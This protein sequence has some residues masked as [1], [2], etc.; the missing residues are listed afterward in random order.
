MPHQ[1]LA[2]AYREDS[3]SQEGDF[4]ERMLRLVE[5]ISENFRTQYP[6]LSNMRLTRQQ[7]TEFLYLHDIHA[8]RTQVEKYLKLKKGLWVLF[9][10]LDKGWSAHGLTAE[11]LLIIRALLDATRKIEQSLQPKGIDCHTI[12]FLRNDVYS[13]L[14]DA[15]PDRGKE[16]RVS[17][18][19]S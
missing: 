9:D 3:Y 5:K 17:L 18:D 4:S 7:V 16:I 11:D 2:R 14:I 19:W 1:D 12:I 8:L 10:N 6:N 13:L 15:T